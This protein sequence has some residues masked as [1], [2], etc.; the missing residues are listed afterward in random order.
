MRLFPVLTL[1][2][3]CSSRAV[4]EAGSETVLGQYEYFLQVFACNQFQKLHG[5]C[6][7]GQD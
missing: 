3:T 7:L 4:F 1:L 2:E 5:L 6:F